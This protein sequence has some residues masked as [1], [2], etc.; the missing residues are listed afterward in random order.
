MV[1]SLAIQTRTEHQFIRFI[2][3]D[4]FVFRVAKRQGVKEDATIPRDE[5][6]K[7]NVDVTA[8]I[9]VVNSGD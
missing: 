4:R 2:Y 9:V 1:R 5:L 3:S 8:E 7:N 6:Q